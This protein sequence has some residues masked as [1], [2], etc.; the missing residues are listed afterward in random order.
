MVATIRQKGLQAM[1]KRP[2]NFFELTLKIK[3]RVTVTLVI[4]VLG[5]TV[6]HWWAPALQSTIEFFVLSVT[7]AAGIF[8]VV[9]LAHT[10][11]ETIDQHKVS[12][13][14]RLIDRWNSPE[15]YNARSALHNVTEHHLKCQND[16]EA[17]KALLENG[18][19][20]SKGMA[21]N[22]RHILNIFEEIAVAIEGG[23]A[24]ESILIE[25]YK[26]PLIRTFEALMPWIG[27]HR[28]RAKCPTLWEHGEKLY[29]KWSKT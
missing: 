28:T 29:I 14:H 18:D 11:L 23:Y 3:I 5:L 15:Y 4:V 8:S 9:Y 17:V 13:A 6:L 21:M 12:L 24:L 1:S 20:T 27:F 2:L 10:L 7:G 26:A 22:I 19:D 16:S 25:L